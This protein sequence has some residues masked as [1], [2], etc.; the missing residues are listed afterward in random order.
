MNRIAVAWPVVLASLFGAYASVLLWNGFNSQEQLRLAVETRL[1][2]EANRH[3]FDVGQFFRKQV[4]ELRELT[5]STPIATYFTNQDL[6]MSPRYGLNANLE[7][8]RNHFSQF[9]TNLHHG[10]NPEP[11]RLRLFD[12]TGSKALVDTSPTIPAPTVTA[13]PEHEANLEIDLTNRHFQL[14]LPIHFKGVKRGY[15]VLNDSCERIKGQAI[16]VDEMPGRQEMLFDSQTGTFWTLNEGNPP[17]PKTTDAVRL[18]A[19]GSFFE[20]PAAKNDPDD[21][22]RMA[23][24]LTI[25]GA[26]I[27]WV[28]LQRQDEL[29]SQVTSRRFLWAS[30]IVPPLLLLAAIH[31]ERMRRRTERLAQHVAETDRAREHL[32][33]VNSDLE[34][35]IRKR[36]AVE[37][38]LREK[39]RI[40]ERMTKELKHSRDQAQIANRAKSEFIAN[41]SHEIRTPMN[42]IIGMSHLCLRTLLTSQQQDYVEKINRSAHSLLRI[43]NEILD[44]SKIEAGRLEIEEVP[45]KIHEVFDHLT[46]LLAI[47]AQEKGLE[48]LYRL[49]PELPE[50]L[51]GDPLRLEQVLLNLSGNAIKFTERGE[52]VISV[53]KESTEGEFVTLRFT[54]ADSGIGMTDEQ[55]AKLFQPFSQADSSTTRRFG[56]TGLG[57]SISKRLVELMQGNIDVTST[58]GVG[59]RFRFTVRFGVEQ[60]VHE[61]QLAL[62]P[63]IPSALRILIVDDNPMAREILGSVLASFPFQV[64]EVDSG[65]A[66]LDRL[67]QAD[68]EGLPIQLVIMDWK[69]PHMDG[70]KSAARIRDLPLTL[71][72]RIIILTAFDQSELRDTVRN[73]HL[74]GYLTKPF[75]HSQLY[76]AIL[77]AFEAD[78][79]RPRTR[80]HFDNDEFKE[81]LADLQGSRLL[82]VEDNE[83]NQQVAKELLSLAGFD[84]HIANHGQQALEMLTVE[85]FSAVLMDIQMPVMDGYQATKQIRNRSEWR[86]L[87]VIAMTANAMAGEKERCL[88]VG[89]NDYISKPI[90]VQLLMS[91]LLRQLHPGGSSLRKPI[92]ETTAARPEETAFLPSMEGFDVAGAI[93]KLGGNRRLYMSLLEKF[94][95]QQ[96]DAVKGIRSAISEHRQTDAIR[97]AHTLKGLGGNLGCAP[98]QELCGSLEHALTRDPDSWEPLV[99]RLDDLMADLLPRI[100]EGL[101]TM[102]STSKDETENIPSPLI[103]DDTRLLELLDHLRPLVHNRNP[104]PCLPILEEMHRLC[105]PEAL[106]AELTKLDQLVRKYRMKEALPLLDSLS[107]R[108]RDE[109]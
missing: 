22:P 16:H 36:E 35:E 14:S 12:A 90:D 25:P 64:E 65:S 94:L 20:V 76:D 49:D 15:L 43:L 19:I 55:V 56:G 54:V 60:G 67:A 34:E 99:A 42:A 11:F 44:F 63:K 84:V 61:P 30:S 13:L 106:Q 109:V 100:R 3:G 48:F 26:G 18:G 79:P 101:A 81:L 28:T 87:P 68:A 37:E 80:K 52:V 86:N 8:I 93:A 88:A 31:F 69:M 53:V 95:E 27:H 102:K 97:A 4:E 21:S 75:S 83:I 74:N 40:L 33:L 78:G 107:G 58:M 85:P 32:Q 91:T 29:Y 45:F 70:L 5:H 89:M 62:P 105:W 47:R 66:A 104:R 92:S 9:L 2:N 17:D 59:S 57:L 77:H 96:Q 98:L 51:R 82:L 72:P 46:T 23:L 39:S 108:L 7:A 10:E 6:G 38:S 71:Q 24:K 1:F 50:H 41:M 103:R 73:R